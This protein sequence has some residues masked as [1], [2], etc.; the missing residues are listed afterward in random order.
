MRKR[1]EM[2]SNGHLPDCELPGAVPAPYICDT[3]CAASSVLSSLM[4][5]SC[6][7]CAVP[8]RLRAVLAWLLGGKSRQKYWCAA[9]SSPPSILSHPP[10]HTALTHPHTPSH[11]ALTLPALRPP[12]TQPNNTHT[13]CLLPTLLPCPPPKGSG[14]G[15]KLCPRGSPHPPCRP[16]PRRSPPLSLLRPAMHTHCPPSPPPSPLAA[17]G[18]DSSSWP[19]SSSSAATA[20]RPWI[21]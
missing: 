4:S 14:Q 5:S 18:R 6:C 11:T 10:S 9:P 2:S 12:R 20:R 21:T 8:S 16:T 15:R 1:Q 13:P 3:S 17:A 19:S 7:S